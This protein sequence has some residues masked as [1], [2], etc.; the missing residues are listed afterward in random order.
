ML[1]EIAFGLAYIVCFRSAAPAGV[2][3]PP[4]SHFA[5]TLC[6][7]VLVLKTAWPSSILRSRMR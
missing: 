7:V 3:H 4:P 5:F 6:Y 2:D 1:P